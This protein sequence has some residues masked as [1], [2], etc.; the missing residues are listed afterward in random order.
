MKLAALFSSSLFLL[1]SCVVPDQEFNP[2]T[3]KTDTASSVSL[4]SARLN[5]TL[6]DEG[7]MCST[8][9]RGFIIS[10]N[11][12]TLIKQG[13]TLNLGN[14]NKGKITQNLENLK[15]KTKYYFTTYAANS[16]HKS[17]GE[18]D[19]FAT[20]AKFVDSI[21]IYPN[22]N[23]EYKLASIE[24]NWK[25][26]TGGWNLGQAPFGNARNN[27]RHDPAGLFDYKTYWGGRSTLYV[28]KKFNLS[29]YNLNTIK[30]HIGVD[31]GYE[32]YINGILVS[33]NS[34]PFYTKRWEYEGMIPASFLKRE[35]NII[36]III[37]DD[38]DLATFDMQLTGKG[39]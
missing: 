20:R 36:A 24:S 5:G 26:T 17:Y 21:I 38:G 29:D 9:N 11:K 3:I 15:E 32:L 37:T 28:R 8:I 30:F 23:W 7:C 19:S 16:K 22:S 12:K 25:I 27:T 18:I 1:G 35:D 10:E 4:N 2:P 33:K 13:K 34:A 39:R 31:N 6:V 14:G